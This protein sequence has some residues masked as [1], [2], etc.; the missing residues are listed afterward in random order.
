MLG[1]DIIFM[2][3]FMFLVS[4]CAILIIDLYLWGYSWYISF[5]LYYVKSRIYFVFTCIF[6]TCIYVSIKCYRNIQVNSVVLLSIL[7]TD[8]W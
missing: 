4:H 7:V 6:Q 5:I 2:F 1:G 3:L 8:R